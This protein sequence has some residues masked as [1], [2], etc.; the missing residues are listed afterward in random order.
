MTTQ[1]DTSAITCLR[2]AGTTFSNLALVCSLLGPVAA[3]LTATGFERKPNQALPQGYHHRIDTR[4]YAQRGYAALIVAT[5]SAD[6]ARL[7]QALLGETPDIS[8][9]GLH[10]AILLVPQR[11]VTLPNP[12]PEG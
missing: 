8:D 6:H 10:E 11:P 1:L 5:P 2:E 9:H 4:R 3:H 7:L 12:N